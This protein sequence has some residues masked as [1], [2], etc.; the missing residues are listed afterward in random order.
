M[1]WYLIK[2]RGLRDFWNCDKKSNLWSWDYLRGSGDKN[3]IWCF[4][5]WWR[6]LRSMWGY[7]IEIYDAFQDPN[8]SFL[9]DRGGDFFMITV[10][11]LNQDQDQR[12]F[13]SGFLIFGCSLFYFRSNFYFFDR[14]Q[15]SRP[16]SISSPSLLL[17]SIRRFLF[18]WSFLFFS[19]ATFKPQTHPPPKNLKHTHLHSITNSA[20]FLFKIINI[21]TTTPLPLNTL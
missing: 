2:E 3:M 10:R 7:F 15:K 1:R 8:R 4:L 9:K 19:V 12:F 18:S 17:I 6:F 20:T 5:S 14:H 13:R 16:R 11:L 21:H